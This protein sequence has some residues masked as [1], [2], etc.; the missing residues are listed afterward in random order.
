MCDVQEHRT[1]DVRFDLLIAPISNAACY[2]SNER[3][4]A[5]KTR[6]KVF[7]LNISLHTPYNSSLEHIIRASFTRAFLVDT[8]RIRAAA[9]LARIA[10]AGLKA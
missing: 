3:L 4:V 9:N 2:L 10:R 1:F 5:E 6:A 8:Q 7:K